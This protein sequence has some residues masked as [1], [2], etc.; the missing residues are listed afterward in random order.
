MKFSGLLLQRYTGKPERGHNGVI[1]KERSNTRRCSDIFEISCWN[2]ERVRV[3]FSF[4]RCDREVMGHIATTGGICGNM[5]SYLMIESVEY[6]FGGIDRLP[7]R[8]ERLSYNGSLIL[9]ERQD[10][11]REC[12]VLRSG[13]HYI[14]VL[15]PTVWPNPL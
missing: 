7:H 8:I 4:D 15:N 12:S 10:K 2:M 3:A 13:R 5:I 1:I 9:P 14:G 6:R 11:L